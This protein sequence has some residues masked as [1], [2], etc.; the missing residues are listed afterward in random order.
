MAWKKTKSQSSRPSKQPR[1]QTPTS[2][3]FMQHITELRKRLF[4]TVLVGLGIGAVAFTYSDPVLKVV[5]APLGHEKLIYL[6]PGGGFSFIFSA[7]LYVTLICL[8]PFILY[9]V[10][11]FLRPA[12]PKR[13][14]HLSI[15]VVL[16]A[17]LLMAA[18][19]TF[20][21]FVAIPNGLQFLMTFASDYVAPSLTAESYLTFVLGYALGIGVLF[22]LPLV[23]MIWHW[24]SPLTTKKL[25]NS[26]RYVILAAFIL[27]AI[28]SPTP[29]AVNQ[30]MIA[31]PIIII[32][33][34]GVI[35]VWL[36]IRRKNKHAKKAA[37]PAAKPPSGPSVPPPSLL[38]DAS[39]DQ[40]IPA[41]PV[42]TPVLRP[43]RTMSIDGFRVQ[44]GA[45]KRTPATQ[46]I[47]RPAMPAVSHQFAARP[48]AA[49]PP[50]DRGRV[51][52]PRRST[53]L[54]SDFGPIRPSAIDIAH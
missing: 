19:V 48:T 15:K 6:T 47:Q 23:L 30:A 46:S 29:D 42:P 54:I 4:R 12:M 17:V 38:L 35:S 40:P 22:E 18:G 14:Q 32:Y 28:I 20:G 16:S 41:A 1:T 31:V 49:K 36:S 27:A 9:Q 34:I 24:I 37:A 2:Q 21:Y 3:T 39:L 50:V 10:Y 13:A 43:A 33:Q 51:V 44:H 26:E 7:V 25:L 11:A 45:S 52:V 53:G 5:M 8:L